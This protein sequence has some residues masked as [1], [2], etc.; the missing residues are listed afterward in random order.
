MKLTLQNR[1]TSLMIVSSILLVSAFT[2]I[3]VNNQVQ[4]IIRYNAY[5]AN[6]STVL[7]KNNLQTMI[8]DAANEDIPG[9][10]NTSIKSLNEAGII[11]Y[12]TVFDA[13][14]KIIASSEKQ[15]SDV[16]PYKDL[17]KFE[18]LK[19]FLTQDKWYIS[20]IDR[21][22]HQ[23]NIYIALTKDNKG[24]PAYVG[25]ISLP[26]ANIG[27]ALSQVYLPVSI[28]IL[29]VIIA[30]IILG[31][32]LS[33]TVIGPIKMLNEVTKIIAAGDLAVRTDI[34]T[35]DEIEELG[36]T[37]NYMTEELVKMKERAENANPL[38]K[39]PGNIV[40][41][42][43]I[44][45]RL[46]ENVK[47]MVI[48]CDL[49]NFK[50]FN[51]KYGIAKGDEAIKLTADVFRDSVKL[52]GNPDDFLGHEGGDDFIL[53]TTPEKADDV[54]NYITSEFDKR[55]R[56]LYNEEDLKAGKIIAH[57]RDGSIKEFPI[58]TISLAGVTN[59]HR[60]IASY[61]EV[62]NIAAEVKKK[63]KAIP[64]SSFVIDKRKD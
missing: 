60:P 25:K 57:A 45:K 31:Y 32:F 62:T 40:I 6:L 23:L 14:G 41:H 19:S 16:V 15:N 8:K 12:L 54:A 26:L 59:V 43:Q 36:S 20:S 5:Q 13:E 55:V 33:R 22:K 50:A 35:N 58:M 44:D 56:S 47:F 53:L 39:L 9:F 51:D 61:V 49:D 37:F 38:T 3:Q 63:S 18:D 2:F 42:E 11:K 10:L 48:Y 7:V 21:F 30:N 17:N 28:A 34:R 24:I 1:I 29:V 52:K 27:E 4:N 46:H 64:G